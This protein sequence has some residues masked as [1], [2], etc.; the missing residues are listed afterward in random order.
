[1]I[2]PVQFS[3]FR[4]PTDQAEDLRDLLLANQKK[5]KYPDIE[6][7]TDAFTITS[8]PKNPGMSLLDHP[9]I[10]ECRQNFHIR[11]RLSKAYQD[12]YFN[13]HLEGGPK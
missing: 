10:P 8:D 2:S 7:A 1:M 11:P 4:I 9:T 3:A 6:G 13:K 12:A 5:I